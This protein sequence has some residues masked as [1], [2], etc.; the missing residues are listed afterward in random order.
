M[1]KLVV[2]GI[3]VFVAAVAGTLATSQFAQGVPAPTA[4]LEQNKDSDGNIKIH[5]QGTA[6]VG[7]TPGGNTVELD[8]DGN[9]VHVL[10]SAANPVVVNDAESIQPFARE[11]DMSAAVGEPLG[12]ADPFQ[13][14]AG[15]RLVIEHLT[16]F[17]DV[18]ADDTLTAV[19]LFLDVAPGEPAVSFVFRPGERIDVGAP[20]A[21]YIGGETVQNLYVRSEGLIAPRFHRQNTSAAANGFLTVSGYLTED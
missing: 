16:Y 13:V 17:V 18:D 21:N 14:P 6:S 9:S 8:P 11:F 12:F 2:L 10:S 3:G 19:E 15:Q 20:R 7:L 1:K 4:V 5:E